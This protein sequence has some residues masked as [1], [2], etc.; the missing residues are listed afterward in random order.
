MR[1]LIATALLALPVAAE[2]TR[3]RSSEIEIL[4]D[5]G[6]KTGRQVLRRFDEIRRIFRQA[7]APAS[8]LAL[9][10]FVFASE[11]EFRSYREDAATDGFYQSA[12][13]RDYIALYAASGAGRVVVHEYVHLVLSHA[14][15]PLPKWFEEGTAE[16]YSTIAVDGARMSVGQPIESH[17]ATLPRARLLSSSELAGVTHASPFYNERALAGM[18]YAQS[19][20]LVHMLNLS[21]AYRGGMPD[22]ALFL[23]QGKAPEQAFRQ[24]F[25]KTMDQALTD[26][27]RYLRSL[28]GGTVAAPPTEA[29]ELPVVERV[30]ALEATLA[31]AD[32]A[33]HAER[34]V[35]ARTL[36][37]QA[38]R[39]H[40]DSPGA[41]AGLGALALAEDRKADA[42]QYLERAIALGARD[43]EV[44]F[45][46]ASLE[47]QRA[48][49]LLERTIALNPNF[50]EAHFLLGV[51]ASDAGEYQ[52]AIR[53]L[54]EAVRIL[55]RQSYFWHALGYA[56]S[57]LGMR[58]EAAESARRALASATTEEHDR[59]AEALLRQT[60]DPL[61]VPSAKR[62]EVVTPST[63]QNPKG[64]ARVEGVLTRVDCL[65]SSAKLHVAAGGKEVILDVRNPGEVELVNAP[66][67]SYQFSC[68][69]QSV[70]IA[71][72]YQ[73]GPHQVTRIEFRP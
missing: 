19:W 9:R 8:S 45:E 3:V 5:A 27:P 14:S 12:P 54:R 32:L 39:E 69:Q 57:R 56:Q 28:R 67:A 33:L 41:A 25:G 53:H 4:T 73:T 29:T 68:G 38:A 30:G 15:A 13:E 16:F 17:M 18:F 10:V 20:A 26:L 7:N 65:G 43:A 64:D 31:R 62:P 36:F 71:V 60:G 52:A 55:P 35:L 48:D 70:R 6:E 63:W 58:E 1:A 50:A 22:F 47:P 23:S 44:Y 34:R 42:R 11:R 66:E 46:L 24:A 72:E 2:W 49:E 40:P 51:R 37:Q 21:P 61:A 59:M